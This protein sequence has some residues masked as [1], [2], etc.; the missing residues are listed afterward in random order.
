MK[1]R[2]R[3]IWVSVK[4][5][6]PLWRLRGHATLPVG[7]QRFRFYGLK[8]PDYMWGLLAR[9]RMYEPEVIAL[10]ERELRPGDTFLDVG[11]HL[12]AFSLLASRLVGKQ[13][14]VLA[15]EP[16]A[17]S[18]RL[19]KLNV[20][21][22]GVQE[23][24]VW[25]DPIAA[26]DRD[27]TAY[28][29]GLGGDGVS[30]LSDAGLEVDCR[31]LDTLVPDR[32]LEPDV[33]KIDVEG[34]EGA[35]LRGGQATLRQ[36]RCVIVELHAEKMRAMGDDPDAVLDGFGQ[37]GEVEALGSRHEDNRNVVVRPR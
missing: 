13:G 5:P 33:V 29:S 27:G 18:W 37:L 23:G 14:R 19:F 34:G 22:N 3:R 32:G 31:T 21:S 30:A 35:V 17:K 36:A 25:L 28:L 10:L 6:V 15:L 8:R 1:E 11:A 7:S 26:S 4:W 20:R 12:G 9:K 24:L 2:L 16:D